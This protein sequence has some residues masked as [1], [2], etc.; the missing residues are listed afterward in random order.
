MVIHIAQ[1]SCKP[2]QC[3]DPYCMCGIHPF[4]IKGQRFTMLKRDEHRAYNK[5]KKMII[6]KKIAETEK[7]IKRE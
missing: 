4:V 3:N 1:T 5:K 6:E 7:N 2:I